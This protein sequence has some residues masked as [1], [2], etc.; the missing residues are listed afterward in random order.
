MEITRD[1][2]GYLTRLLGLYLNAFIGDFRRNG[3]KTCTGSMELREGGRE[4]VGREG[5]RRGRKKGEGKDI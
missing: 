5:G 2:W 1:Y 3:F 4:E